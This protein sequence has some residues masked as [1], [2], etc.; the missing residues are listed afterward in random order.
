MLLI[1]GTCLSVGLAAEEVES[2]HYIWTYDDVVKPEQMGTF[3]EARIADA[4]LCAE[5]EFEFP[6]LTYV[7]DFRVYTCGR[8]DA[9]AQLDTFP[10]M[11]EAWNEKTGGKSKE[12]GQQIAKSISHSTTSIAV[13]RPDLSYE[14]KKPAFTPDFSQPFFQVAKFFHIKPDKYE[15]LQVLAR[16]IKEV[17]EQRQTPQGYRIYELI[18]GDGVPAFV[19]AMTAKDEISFLKLDKSIQEKYAHEDA[20]IMEEA[21]SLIT[22]TETRE[23]TFVPEASYVP[24][25]DETSTSKPGLGHKKLEIIVGDWSYAGHVDSQWQG[26]EF[27]PAGK[28]AGKTSSRFVLNGFFVEEHWEETFETG[29]DSSGTALFGYDASTD[30]HVSNIFLNSGKTQE[31][32]YTICDNTMT[33]NSTITSEDGETYLVKA[34]WQFAP[35]RD[36]FTSVWKISVDNGSTW[37]PW[38]KYK[39]AKICKPCVASGTT[40]KDFEEFCKL[41]EGRWVCDITWVAD[42]PGIGKKG[43]KVT[44]Y[45]QCTVTEDG[46]ALIGKFYGGNGSGTW[47][48]G[49]DAGARQI[50]STFVRSGGYVGQS[51]IYKRCGN[52][53]IKGAG[54]EADG[55]KAEHI[56]TVAF[57]D[58]GN[59]RTETGS[60]M[61]GDKEIDVPGD[62]WRRVS[63]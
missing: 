2:P 15:E 25:R 7:D 39:G 47:L 14:P 16:K 5:R 35:D 50:T 26:T 11:M 60:V 8:F 20:K 41:Q 19:V 30:K 34:V 10:Q 38:A 44:A 1:I 40:R 6:Y 33:G 48:A 18:C 9:F 13:F 21:L 32:T 36:S 42:W 37:K 62:V 58:N 4:K 3:M 27:G 57:T 22:K 17:D 54:S 23:G 43:D 31:W 46:N 55:T 45:S 49:F 24:G 59:T 52:W 12:I 28:F 29:E 56:I 61:V 63:K 51:I 53:V